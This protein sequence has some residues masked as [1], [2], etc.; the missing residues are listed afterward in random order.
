[1]YSSLLRVR[2][3]PH[4]VLCLQM[5][6]AEASDKADLRN[7]VLTYLQGTGPKPPVDNAVE[8][9]LAAKAAVVRTGTRYNH[10]C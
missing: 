4:L 10:D 5:W 6:V 3:L 7:L 9:Y 1:M 8:F 2:M